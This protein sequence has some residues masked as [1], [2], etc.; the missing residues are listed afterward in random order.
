MIGIQTVNKFV[1]LYESLVFCGIAGFAVYDLFKRR[2][3]DRA[4]ILFCL[5]ASISPL[6]QAWPSI[7]WP[8]LLLFFLSN[9]AGAAMGFFVLLGAAIFTKSGDGIGGGDI[10][11]AAV[12]GFIYGPFRI[13]IILFIASALAAVIALA[14]RKKRLAGQ[15]S[16]P[17]VPF[18]A[19][20]SLAVTAAIFIR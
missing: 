6:V 3:P 18:L 19:I 20:G 1:I 11:L 9:L 8:L 4:L 16:L 12:M 10:K 7:G 15:L 13:T 17:F 2:V 14:I 5:A